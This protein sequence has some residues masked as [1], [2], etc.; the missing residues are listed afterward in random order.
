MALQ[1]TTAIATI[2]LQ[3][4]SSAVTFSGIPNTYR[5]LILTIDGGASSAQSANLYLNADTNTASY[6]RV[7]MYGDGASAV[8]GATSNPRILDIGTS[9]SILISSIFDYSATDKHKTVLVRS[10]TSGLVAASAMRW[11]NLTA[12]NQ[13]SAVAHTGTFNSGTSFSLYGRIA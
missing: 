2:T 8:S 12:V 4:A 13:I 3:Q 1:S 11:A 7:T 10:N 9:A 5:D 6:P